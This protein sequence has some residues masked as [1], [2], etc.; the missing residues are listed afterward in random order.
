MR[1]D[2]N[3]DG[4]FRMQFTK[5]V[6]TAEDGKLQPIV[7]SSDYVGLTDDDIGTL[8]IDPSMRRDGYLYTSTEKRPTDQ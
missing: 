7:E 2:S 6:Q 8:P 3:I 1:T 4:A 5:I